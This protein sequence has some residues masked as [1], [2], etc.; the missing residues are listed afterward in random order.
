MDFLLLE[1]LRESLRL[2][3]FNSPNPAAE[4]DAFAVMDAVAAEETGCALLGKR[5]KPLL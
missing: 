3:F 5:L 2:R 1:M 4:N